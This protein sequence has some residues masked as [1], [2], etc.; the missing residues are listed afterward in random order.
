MALSLLQAAGIVDLGKY[1]AVNSQYQEECSCCSQIKHT[2]MCQ[3]L[4]QNLLNPSQ[5]RI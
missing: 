4:K 3:L 2:N 1:L 5:Q